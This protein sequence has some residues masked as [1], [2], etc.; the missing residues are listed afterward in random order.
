L[1]NRVAMFSGGKDGLRAAQLSWPVDVFL[2]LVYEF[3][4]P[5]PT[6]RTSPRHPPWPSL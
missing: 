1:G 6:S 5:S 3:P 4:E 2:F